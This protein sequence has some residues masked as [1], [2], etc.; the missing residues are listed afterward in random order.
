MLP[1][2]SLAGTLNFSHALI[3]RLQCASGSAKSIGAEIAFARNLTS[4]SEIAPA[5][6]SVLTTVWATYGARAAW[7]DGDDQA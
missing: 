7:A 2:S 5:L 1:G 3:G 4:R 6:K